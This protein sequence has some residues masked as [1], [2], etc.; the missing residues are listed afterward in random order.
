[1]KQREREREKELGSFL[2][3]YFY[4]FRTLSALYFMHLCIMHLLY[5]AFFFLS[6]FLEKY[7]RDLR[8]IVSPQHGVFF[9]QFDAIVFDS[10]HAFAYVLYIQQLFIEI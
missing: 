3:M 1:M 5:Y 7:A 10:A 2:S 6:F 8:R 9:I 4:I